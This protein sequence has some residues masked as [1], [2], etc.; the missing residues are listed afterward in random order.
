MPTTS[1]NASGLTLGID[2]DG[3]ITDAPEFFSAWTHSWPGK[4]IIITFRS[5]RQKAIDDLASRNIKWN[6]LVLVDRFDA[7]AEIIEEKNVDLY[8]DDQPEMLINIKS[9]TH[10]MLFRNGGN[11][12]FDEKKWML[13]EQTGKLVC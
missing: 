3:V 11:Y 10:V 9:K 13:S 5:D 12:D 4:V 2:L 7:K 8:I 6:E 1:Q